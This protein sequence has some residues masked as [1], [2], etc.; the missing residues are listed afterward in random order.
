MS[1]DLKPRADSDPD[2]PPEADDAGSE[3]GRLRQWDET[4][5]WHPFTA[6][7]RQADALMIVKGEGHY[8]ID[9]DGNR[10]LDGIASLSSNSFGHRRPEMD[11][12]ITEQLG[13]I[14]HT[15]LFGNATDQAV[16]LAHRLVEIAPQGLTRVFFSDSPA[17]AVEA[18]LKMAYQYWQQADGG[19]HSARQ[20]FL[21]LGN[22]YHGDS[23]GALSLG[24]I[25]RFQ[26]PY[27]KLL[28][29]TLHAHSPYCYRC[30]NGLTRDKCVS[31]CMKELEQ[32]AFDNAGR[33]AGIVIEPGL[34]IPGGMITQPEGYLAKI[35]DIADKVGALLIH[36][37]SM[38]GLGRSGTMFASE[39]LGVTPDFLC[40]ANGLTGGYLPMAVTLTSE[41]IFQAF[42]GGGGGARA[43]YHG[44][45]FAGNALAAA[46]ALAT[47]DIF[48]QDGILD[49]LPD[50]ITRLERELT[51]LGQFPSV[52]E[53]RQFGLAA[54]IE[55]VAD[56]ASKKPFPREER[57]GT[58][59]AMAARSHGA[60][61]GAIG[62][63]VILMPPL[64]IEEEEIKLL[65]DAVIAGIGEVCGSEI[66]E[67]EEEAEAG[68][69]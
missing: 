17:G 27:R 3:A 24:G 28:F 39:R 2:E 4:H 42:D 51:R 52:G 40:I 10:Y 56:A 21:S 55:L 44:D 5:L 43:F 29:T 25:E 37:E 50:K 67:T 47:L 11:A 48:E 34:Q 13:R 36:D 49:A 30:P 32:V 7:E 35:H 68:G 31:D 15:T 59:S 33:I 57:R 64:T 62:D 12:A 26:Q 1:E 45:P 16:T 23:I 69:S 66:T 14:A 60:F 63:V 6:H 8:L 9:I 58:R 65:V 22:A 46:A 54:G 18:A 19:R 41:K 38:L 20:V 61:V 53:V